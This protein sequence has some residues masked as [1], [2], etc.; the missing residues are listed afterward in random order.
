MR[1]QE[2]DSEVLDCYKKKAD[3]EM[4][5]AFLEYE[6]WHSQC[7]IVMRVMQWVALS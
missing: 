1:C 4:R 2:I 6:V 3:L 7:L 5:S